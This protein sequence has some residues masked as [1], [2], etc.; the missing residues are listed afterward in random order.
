MAN[1]NV[2]VTKGSGSVT[3]NGT[4]GEDVTDKLVDVITDILFDAKTDGSLFT[5]TLPPAT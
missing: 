1:I 2:T 4:I 3:L 5:A